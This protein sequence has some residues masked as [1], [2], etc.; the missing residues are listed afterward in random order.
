MKQDV[1]QQGIAARAKRLRFI[2]LHQRFKLPALIACHRL[3]QAS[4]VADMGEVRQACN[5]VAHRQRVC[6][7]GA[8]GVH[9]E[10]HVVHAL[11]AV[12]CLGEAALL[13]VLVA[14]GVGA[15]AVGVAHAKTL[16]AGLCQGE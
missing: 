7:H 15:A 1:L 3:P 14:V 11:R 16:D 9:L 13:P 4:E 12:V 6:V 8:R 10:P 2:L 5:L